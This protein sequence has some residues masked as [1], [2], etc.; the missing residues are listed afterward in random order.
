MNETDL[1][2]VLHRATDRIETPGLA[3][4]A[5][6]RAQQRRALRHGLFAAGVAAAAVVAVVVGVRVVGSDGAAPPIAPSPPPTGAELVTPTQTPTVDPI[7]ASIVQ[8]EWDPAAV[9]DLP[10][11]EGLG[12]PEVLDPPA[13]PVPLA[14][15]PIIAAV[16]AV[17]TDE[18]I[19]VVDA[20]GA[21]RSVD[22]PAP[23]LSPAYVRDTIAISPEGT[24]VAFAGDDRLWWRDVRGG[25]WRS[26]PYPEELDLQ[27]EWDLRLVLHGTE[28]LLV[29]G[30]RTPVDGRSRAMTWAVD[31]G[32][33]EA[34]PVPYDLGRSAVRQNTV[35]TQ[36]FPDTR[37][38]LE[39]RIDGIVTSYAVDAYDSLLFLTLGET[40]VAAARESS[41]YHLPREDAERDGLLAFDLD[42]GRARAY[43]PVDDENAWYS[44]GGLVPLAWV[45][46]DVVL[47]RVTP[48]DSGGF[49]SGTA[50]LVTWDVESGALARVSSYDVTSPVVVAPDLLVTP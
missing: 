3:T 44:R 21:W 27:A 37:R 39:R 28:E 35:V 11:A 9:T 29:N 42:T 19:A 18:G 25:P 7:D 41:S 1:H 15:Q 40:S 22:Q 47:A 26:V 33:G 24:R 2:D 6:L 34:E 31:L 16:A 49:D 10:L 20:T 5:M 32:D 8:P 36:T 4:T 46:D 48:K 12:L 23:A 14:D 50:H 45:G 38:V 43:L 30:Y 13:N 17:D